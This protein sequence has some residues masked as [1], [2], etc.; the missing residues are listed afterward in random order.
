MGWQGMAAAVWT[1]LAFQVLFTLLCGS[2]LH[3]GFWVPN[4]ALCLAGLRLTLNAAHQGFSAVS[5]PCITSSTAGGL[6]MAN[7]TSRT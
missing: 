5:V 1:S 2:A 4:I 6:F 3:S 7:Y